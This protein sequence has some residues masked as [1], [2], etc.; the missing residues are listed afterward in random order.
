L[1]AKISLNL[2]VIRVEER[3]MRYR[4]ADLLV[5]PSR[6]RVTRGEN[7]IALPKLSFD[8]L[9]VLIQEAPN[10]VK[11]DTLID[12]VWRGLVVSPE[13][14]IQRVKLLRDALGDDPKS[15]RYIES[16]RG[17]GYQLIAPVESLSME[18]APAAASAPAGNPTGARGAVSNEVVQFAD[19]FY[20][21]GARRL[22]RAGALVRLDSRMYD[23]LDILIDRSPSVVCDAE[24]DRLLVA[25]LRALLGD[26]AR[27]ARVIRTV[28]GQGY[29]FC[30]ELRRLGPRVPPPADVKMLWGTKQWPL[31]DGE[32]IMGRG[33]ECALVI[34]ASTVSR[35]H[36]KLTI[37]QQQVFIEDL[38]S[39]NGTHVD[40]VEIHGLAPLK[41]GSRVTLGHEPLT[42]QLRNSATVTVAASSRGS[43]K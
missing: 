30:A 43:S 12:K 32:H 15:P 2:T 36:A 27:E 11:I 31:G 21:R 37:R 13:T 19:C 8:L 16:L 9:L 28:D 1:D 20:D 41:D 18:P 26:D 38:G 3:A 34:D 42:V 40:G 24:V 25:E 10:L 6:G 22:L 14:V 17:F 23:L 4:V 39:K 35:R 7:K 5:E 33:D 29:A